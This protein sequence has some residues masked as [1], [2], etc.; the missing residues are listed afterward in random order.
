[1]VTTTT[2][3]KALKSYYLDTVSDMLDKSANP[4][5]AAIKKTTSDVW[6]RDVRKTVRIGV[7]GGVGAGTEEGELPKAGSNRYAQLVASLKNLYGTIEISDKA[8]RSSAN[9]AGA[10]VNLLNDEM[11]GLVKSSS[12]NLG[13][14]LFGDGTGTLAT[15]KTAATSS[16]TAKPAI[17]DNVKNVAEGMIVDLF[18]TGTTSPKATGLVITAVDRVN[19][20]IT[21]M[22]GDSEVTVAVSDFITLQN[23]YGQELT[24]L[25][26]ICAETGT[27][28]G[29]DKAAN[30]WMKPYAVKNAGMP[31]EEIL[32]K[33]IDG[34]EESAGGKINF[35]VTSMGVRRALAN[36]LIYYRRF[37]AAHFESGMNGVLTFNGIPIV[38]DRFC[39]A[40]TAYLLNTDDFALHQLCDWQW[41]ESEEGK[42]LKQI[43]GKPVYTAT[44][45]KYAELMCYRPCGQAVVTGLLET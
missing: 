15:V 43:P 19:K 39:P 37:E 20:Y 34:V 29:I 28:Y 18:A 23:S 32:Q 27:L 17:W 16:G 1:M 13:R 24:G 45:V 12:F 2:A 8:I 11:D 33:A 7:N 26:A 40:Q 31:S 44:L 14:M 10:F 35:I 3:D 36:E 5:L 6:G 21:L 4:F 22:N 30:P 38:A 41:L 42:V 25:G 9:N